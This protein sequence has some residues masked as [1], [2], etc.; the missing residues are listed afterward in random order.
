MLSGFQ[1]E[2][3]GFIFGSLVMGVGNEMSEPVYTLF[4]RRNGIYKA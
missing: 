3:F 4:R 1:R 2:E